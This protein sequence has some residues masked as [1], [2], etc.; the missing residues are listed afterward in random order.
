VEIMRCLERDFVCE[1]SLLRL[2]SR[3]N[4]VS[5]LGVTVR[6]CYCMSVVAM[7]TTVGER[8]CVCATTYYYLSPTL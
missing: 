4:F 5:P 8:S 6:V 3:E 2:E 7:G 1:S